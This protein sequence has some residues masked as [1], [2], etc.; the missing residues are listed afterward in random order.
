MGLIK[1]SSAQRKSG[2]YSNFLLPLGGI[3]LSGKYVLRTA[4]IPNSSYNINSSNNQLYFTISSTAKTASIPVGYYDQLTLPSAVQTAMNAVS[5]GFTV[6][7]NATPS[8]ITIANATSFV[9][10]NSNALNSIASILGF[11]P[12]DTTAGTST[13]STGILDLSP[14]MSFNI[15]ISDQ[16]NVQIVINNGSTS[17]V[18][19]TTFIVPVIQDTGFVVYYEPKDRLQQIINF[20]QPMTAL[21]ITVTDD[22]GNNVNLLADWYIIIDPI[23]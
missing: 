7:F 11:T 22:K 4:Y 12:V 15:N 1:L 20:G 14:L 6:S 5:S 17:S 3:K 2:T 13:T 21:E 8:T 9:L 16:N 18:N 23:C 10:N 19:A